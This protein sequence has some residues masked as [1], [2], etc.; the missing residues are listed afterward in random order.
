MIR[1]TREKTL[2]GAFFY[3][4]LNNDAIFVRCKVKGDFTGSPFGGIRFKR[5]ASIA[6][7]YIHGGF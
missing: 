7:V 3:A 2:P 4:I 5:I 6:D 1:Y